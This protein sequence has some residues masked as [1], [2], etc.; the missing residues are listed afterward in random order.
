MPAKHNSRSSMLAARGA[1]GF[2][3]RAAGER[4]RPLRT[5]RARSKE[6]NSPNVRDRQFQHQ[7]CPTGIH[8]SSSCE[9]PR[10]RIASAPVCRGFDQLRLRIG[11]MYTL[12]NL[13]NKRELMDT[14]AA[15]TGLGGKGSSQA[16]SCVGPR[17]SRRVSR[18]E[19]IPESAS[20]MP[21]SF[22]FPIL[23]RLSGTDGATIAS[24]R[25]KANHRTIF[26]FLFFV[27]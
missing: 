27:L 21:P 6:N 8:S 23:Y 2:P 10:G 9:F 17:V 22:P 5:R 3:G 18:A 7:G 25:M 13:R 19:Y 26:S 1:G 12:A 15:I 16:F 14:M 11:I 4:P 20:R 24:V